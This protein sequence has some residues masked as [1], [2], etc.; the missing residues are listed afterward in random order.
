MSV[1]VS[2]ARRPPGL[3]APRPAPAWP[4][5][6]SALVRRGLLDRRRSIAVWGGSLGALGAFMAAIYPTIRSSIEQVV[7]SY[8]AGLKQAF[9]VQS[10]STVEG[11]VHA[12]LFSL[13][14]PLAI[15]YFAVRAVT[16]PIVGAEA[17][18][19]LDTILSLP[20]RRTVLMAG[21]CLVAA[22]SSAA[23]LALLGLATFVVGRLAG[24]GI[25]LGLITAGVAGVF[26]LALFA[27][28]LAALA[29]GA[30]RRSLSA[31]GL[32][33]GAMVA[34]YALDLAGRLAHSL[35]PLRYV[36][37]FHYY[38]D[39]IQNG[40]DPASFLGLGAVG[41]LLMI[42]GAVLFERRDVRH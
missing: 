34:M 28:G 42:A 6:L 26:P 32:A 41:V 20:L 11:Y 23:I 33:M 17:R 38:G 40:I 39:P 30:L 5:S 9:G 14:V 37:A 3:P 7:K 27:G 13:I 4:Q 24:T 25:S 12:E 31:S 21:A 36:S 15:A 10:M 19:E 29:S 1:E 18:S 8:P 16:S 2:P 22:V 35:G